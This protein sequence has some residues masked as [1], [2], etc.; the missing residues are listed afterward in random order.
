MADWL[1]DLLTDWLTGPLT[2]LHALSRART[3]TC[4]QPHTLH[5]THRKLHNLIDRLLS[6][7]IICCRLV[8]ISLINDILSSIHHTAVKPKKRLA[9][10]HSL[11]DNHPPSLTPTLLHLGYPF[12]PSL[13]EEPRW[14]DGT[15]ASTAHMYMYDYRRRRIS[16]HL[17]DQESKKRKQLYV[18]SIDSR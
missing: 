12:Q 8:S 13:M 16:V 6:G 5:L 10:G 3:L 1:A 9:D 2:C 17:A 11:D 14:I 15:N 7:Q 18:D 4:L